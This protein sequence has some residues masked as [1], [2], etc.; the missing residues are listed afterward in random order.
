MRLFLPLLPFLLLA[1]AA[2]GC[3]SKSPAESDL[4]PG[5]HVNPNRPDP[6]AIKKRKQRLLEPQMGGAPSRFAEHR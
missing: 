3:G 5:V 2:V 6:E 4:P 1:V